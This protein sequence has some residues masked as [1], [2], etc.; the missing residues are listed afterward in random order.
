MAVSSDQPFEWN[1]DY[2]FSDHFF[3]RW[4]RAELLGAQ[5]FNHVPLSRDSFFTR[6]FFANLQLGSIGSR[7][8][9]IL[10]SISRRLLV[11]RR[12]RTRRDA[13]GMEKRPC[14]L[15]FDVTNINS[16]LIRWTER[17]K[18]ELRKQFLYLIY[19][20]QLISMVHNV[21]M[22]EWRRQTSKYL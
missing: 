10:T 6:P 9:T 16:G 8:P 1:V 13:L 18:V 3:S 15:E 19:E 4:V 2:Y 22:A 11:L 20:D 21:R 5:P 14:R 17:Y 12:W 7:M